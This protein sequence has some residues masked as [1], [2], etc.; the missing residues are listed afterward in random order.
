MAAG[1]YTS[2]TASATGPITTT[3]DASFAYGFGLS[4]SY[5]IIGGLSLGVAPQAIFTVRDKVDPNPSVSTTPPAGKEYDLMA[6]V[7]YAFQVEDT[8]A[9]Y[10]EVLPGYSILQQGGNG[11]AAKGF[12]LAFGGGVAMNV[13]NRI[14]TNLGVGY[15]LG[16]Q[17]LPAADLSAEV[18]TKYVRVALGGGVR[19]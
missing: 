13:T 7:A 2:Q 8:I 6:R 17:K 3:G 15:Q 1:K 5:R 12:V 18:R 19:F 11:D 14:F 9:L 16:F 4:A 10:L